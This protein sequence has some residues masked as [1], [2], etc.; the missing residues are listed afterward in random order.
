MEPEI[1]AK[2]TRSGYRIHEVP[3]SYHPR[4]GGKK[5]SVK[6]DGLPALQALLRYRTWQPPQPVPSASASTARQNG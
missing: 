5:L 2:V 4:A 6:K 3:I 1:T